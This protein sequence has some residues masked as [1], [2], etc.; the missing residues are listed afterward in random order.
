M[1]RWAI[2]GI[3]THADVRMAPAIASAPDTELAA[4][5]S[6]DQ[7]RAETFAHK[8]RARRSYDGYADLLAAPDVDVVY[9]A[10]PNGLHREH[11]IQAARAGKH[12][13]CE[14]PMAL[15]SAD[16]CDMIE[17]C[18]K[19]GVNL[20]L[21]FQNRH[22]P[23]HQA[24]RRLVATGEA[25]EIVLATAQYNHNFP[26]DFE[27]PG[28]RA[29]HAMAGGGSL[30]GMGVHALDLLR[31]VLGREVDEVMAF[32]D[33]DV[34]TS[35][36]DT[37]VACLLR[38]GGGPH[39][40]VSCAL[41]VP[42]AHNDLVLHG[43]KLRIEAN[44]TIGMPWQGSLQVTK[45]AETTI[46]SFPCRNPVTDLYVKLVEDFNGSV[47]DGSEPLATG[48]DGLAMVRLAEAIIASARERK[49][50]R[51]SSAKSEASYG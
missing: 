1:V 18:E 34:T 27:W 3:G 50:V 9:I 6:R 46:T 44:G 14:K 24:A 12:V 20:G 38:F 7:A 10:T 40:F 25:G 17:A 19:A 42:H 43:S 37:S 49:A 47:V 4:V 48:H 35:R 22:H 32:S 31:F 45:G 39:A 8:H 5:W 2:A 36:V 23:A 28:W 41:H 21:A 13:L 15:T 29:S 11:T 16:A 33:E 26:R 51:V 30:M